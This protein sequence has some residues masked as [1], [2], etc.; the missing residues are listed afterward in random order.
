MCG[1][2]TLGQ[3]FKICGSPLRPSP[4]A[5]VLCSQKPRT[6]EGQDGSGEFSSYLDLDTGE[7]QRLGT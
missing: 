2:V 1:C 3:Q 7:D 5:Q 6:Y 4:H